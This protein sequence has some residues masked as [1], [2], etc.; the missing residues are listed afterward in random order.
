VLIEPFSYYIKKNEFV[1]RLILCKTTCFQFVSCASYS[2]Q[3]IQSQKVLSKRA[4]L[5]QIHSNFISTLSHR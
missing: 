3:G 4:H 1:H 5:Y 2:K